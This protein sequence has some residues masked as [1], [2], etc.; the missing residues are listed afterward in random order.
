M[1]SE[2][3]AIA[4]VTWPSAWYAAARLQKQTAENGRDSLLHAK[5]AEYCLTASEYLPASNDLFPAA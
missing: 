1:A 4:S 3:S 2:Q 5:A